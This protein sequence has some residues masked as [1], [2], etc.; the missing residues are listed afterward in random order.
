MNRL[1]ARDEQTAM[2]DAGHDTSSS[3]P[4]TRSARVLHWAAG[5]LAA[6][7][8]HIADLMMPPVCLHC[9]APLSTHDSLC[10]AC[11]R[12]I[13]FIRPPLCQRL[14]I[15]LPFDP[16]GPVVS[17]AAEAQPPA[18]DRARAVARFDDVVRDL[19]HALKFHDRHDA[20][21]IFGRWMAEAGRELL[22]DA[23]LLVSV[24]L[25]RLRL[26]QRRFNQS[27]LLAD[28]VSRVTGVPHD[29]QLLVRSRRTA[30]QVGLNQ[31]QRRANVAGA[32]AVAQG[33]AS[34]VEGRR[35]VLVDDVVTT[36]ATA[37]ACAKTLR[38]AGAVRVD[39]LALALVYDAYATVA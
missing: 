21:G 6:A 11:W 17:A 28:E 29:P 25:S 35:I 18:Y 31:D 16:G 15:P 22:A 13:T 20:R 34:A 36:G 3:P 24:P 32:F 14:G 12:R 27:A 7:G 37:E 8:S 2:T 33:R 30:P 9:H 26:L 23:D 38:K 5:A 19:V 4:R 10:P 39:V 1:N